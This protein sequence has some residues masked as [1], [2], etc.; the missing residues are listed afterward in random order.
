MKKKPY[1]DL[2][3]SKADNEFVRNARNE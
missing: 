3:F 2:L 1:V